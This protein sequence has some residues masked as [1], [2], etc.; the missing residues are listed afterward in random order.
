MIVT[1]YNIF[2]QAQN[3]KSTEVSGK[4][5][6][7]KATD[8]KNNICGATLYALRKN[9]SPKMSQRI[10]AEKCQLLG[11]DIDKNAVQ[12]IESGQRFVTD[13][14]LVCFCKILNVSLEEL[15]KTE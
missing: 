7:N 8:G 5:F 12:R 1:Y 6:K 10:F 9:A 11:L 15:L 2:C 3:V 4:M 14:E 13:I